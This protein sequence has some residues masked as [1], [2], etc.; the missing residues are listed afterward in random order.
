MQFASK[1]QQPLHERGA[2]DRDQTMA[3]S[4]LQMSFVIRAKP[5]LP[6]GASDV[7]NEAKTAGKAGGALV[8]GARPGF[9]VDLQKTEQSNAQRDRCDCNTKRFPLATARV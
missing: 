4:F 8:R 1:M 7:N 2:F 3:R 5:H 6:E 9:P